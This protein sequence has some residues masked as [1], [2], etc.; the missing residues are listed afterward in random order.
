MRGNLC[1]R[2]SGDKI[3]LDQY[4]RLSCEHRDILVP[5]SEDG[6]ALNLARALIQLDKEE[7]F[8]VYKPIA[9][10]DEVPDMMLK[11]NVISW[12][13]TETSVNTSGMR[14][15]TQNMVNVKI[16]IEKVRIRYG[17]IVLR[18]CCP[19]F[20]DLSTATVQ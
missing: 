8:C 20:W 18:N 2:F 3:D 4:K 15:P 13:S 7:N 11:Y 16:V 1:V 17:L 10:D 6:D 5:V 19:I 9:T 12:E 14:G